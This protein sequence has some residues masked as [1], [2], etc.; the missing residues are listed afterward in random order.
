MLSGT[1]YTN[2]FVIRSSRLISIIR[3]ISY[4]KTL[5]KSKVSTGDSDAAYANYRAKIVP[6][7]RCTK[8]RDRRLPIDNCVA[9][10]QFQSCGCAGT[11]QEDCARV[12]LSSFRLCSHWVSSSP[13][14][15]PPGVSE[16]QEGP[17]LGI[18]RVD[19]AAGWRGRGKGCRHSARSCVCEWPDGYGGIHDRRRW[20]F[21]CGVRAI[22]PRIKH[23]IPE[24]IHRHSCGEQVLTWLKNDNKRVCFPDRSPV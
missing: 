7:S 24:E 18:C 22:K 1:A 5:Q 13:A 12:R 19:S 3:L 20:P 15:V 2:S 21:P 16:I 23:S 4:Q 14:D 8:L 10:S 9:G 17:N 6:M 11:H